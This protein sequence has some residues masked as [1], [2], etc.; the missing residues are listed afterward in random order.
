MATFSEGNGVVEKMW[1]E[2]LKRS[3]HHPQSVRELSEGSMVCI[4]PSVPP[5]LPW[6][7]AGTT[8]VRSAGA[9]AN[10]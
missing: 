2:L 4:L 6:T 3:Y 8:Y 7:A 9:A 5:C 1:V 10:M